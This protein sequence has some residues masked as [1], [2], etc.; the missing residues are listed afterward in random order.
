MTEEELAKQKSIDEKAKHTVQVIANLL[1]EFDLN[2]EISIILSIGIAIMMENKIPPFM[3]INHIKGA[4]D[5]TWQNYNENRLGELW[6]KKR[7]RD[8]ANQMDASTDGV[9]V[10]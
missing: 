8:K 9:K 6:K 10:V 7:E 1:G 4:I 2:E 3:F 5:S